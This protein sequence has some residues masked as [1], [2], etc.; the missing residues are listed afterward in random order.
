MIFELLLKDK[1]AVFRT[2]FVL[3]QRRDIKGIIDRPFVP[4]LCF[5]IIAKIP[6]M[7]CFIKQHMCAG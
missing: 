1:Q 7:S 2:L 4:R 3:L 5:I 6:V